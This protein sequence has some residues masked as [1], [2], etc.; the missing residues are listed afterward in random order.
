MGKS[1]RKIKRKVLGFNSVK[2]TPSKY[3][4]LQA[5]IKA[6]AEHQASVDA[7]YTVFCCA[8]SVIWN[9]WGKLNRKKTRLKNFLDL[10]R[11]ALATCDNPTEDMV[12]AE[13][14]LFNQ[15]GMKILREE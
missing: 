6:E 13:M 12:R 3:N 5:Q 10:Y 11:Q 8:V 4:G 9:N 7:G 2:L 14:E 1:S 15:T